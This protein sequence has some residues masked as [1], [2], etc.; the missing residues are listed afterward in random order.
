MQTQ[1]EV[2][3]VT[4][5]TSLESSNRCMIRVPSFCSYQYSY[6]IPQNISLVLSKPPYEVNE[7]GW[8]EF[9]I[10]IKVY[11]MDPVERPVRKSQFLIWSV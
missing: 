8:G 1:P 7:T 9:E 3:I 4:S 2:N 6:E 10:Q 11:F 5:L